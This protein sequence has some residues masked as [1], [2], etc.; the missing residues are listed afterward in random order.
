MKKIFIQY[1]ILIGIISTGLLGDQENFVVRIHNPTEGV[2]QKY[3]SSEYDIAAYKPG[4]YLDLVVNH[5]LYNELKN[6]GYAITITQTE[7]QLI[8]N[9][10]GERDLD[11]YRNYADLLE[12]LQEIES[13]NPDICKLYDIGNSRGKEY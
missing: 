4:K 6:E 13:Q 11:G 10:R 2:V 9:I 8:Q 3:R 12:E 1:S 7:S 5:N